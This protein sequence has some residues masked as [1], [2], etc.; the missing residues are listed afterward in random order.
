MVDSSPFFQ[1][2][3]WLRREVA[4][5]LLPA[6][7][8]RL[9][10][11]IAPTSS[12]SHADLRSV[13]TPVKT[14]GPSQSVTRLLI[15]P[16]NFGG[17]GYRWARAA[18]T[19][20]GVAAVN[21]RFVRPGASSLGPSDFT[22]DQQVGR[23]SHLWARRQKRA[24]TTSVTHVLLEAGQTILGG[25]HGS[26]LQAE[27]AALQ[28]AGIKVG[29][30]SHG[31][32]VRSPALHRTLEPASPFHSALAGL[33]ATL[34]AKTAAT[35]ARMDE[36]S[37]PEFVSTPDLLQYRP[38]ATWLPLTTDPDLWLGVTPTQLRGKKLSVLHV[39]GGA[40]E[41]KGTADIRAAMRRLEAEGLVEYR[42]V[43]GVPH[44]A[45]PEL[46][47][48]ADVVVN[49]VNMGLYAVVAVEA[50]FA[51]RIVVS[52]VGASTRAHIRRQVGVDLPI[53]E[54]SAAS[55]YDAV[56][57]IALNREDYRDLGEQSRQFAL[58][59]HSPV[60]AAEVLR[61]FLEDSGKT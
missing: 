28:R 16:A 13:A 11:R 5:W 12:W 48:W 42:E 46:L 32:D 24:L 15:G 50:M 30:I 36:L 33:T 41:L 23:R 14:R 38:N 49:Q 18:E 9:R 6:L 17:Q 21:L 51:G 39:P 43:S 27:V 19:L 60:R 47:A 25:L 34:E 4:A 8:V 37:L 26:D 57:D 61:P 54:A 1:G 59:A 45:M 2:A 20:P 53:V 55:L 3:A 10:A 29:L 35:H 40:P 52:Q 31:S 44:A 58:T 22:V 7:P 56:R